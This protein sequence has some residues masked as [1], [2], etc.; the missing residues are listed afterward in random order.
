MISDSIHSISI[1][2]KLKITSL[3]DESITDFTYHTKIYSIHYFNFHITYGLDKIRITKN[4][5]ENNLYY[6]ATLQG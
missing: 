3:F 2:L 6:N 5:R 4:Y 1:T